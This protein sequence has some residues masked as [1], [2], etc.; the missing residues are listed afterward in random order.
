MGTM[1]D[2]HWGIWTLG[3]FLAEAHARRARVPAVRWLVLA[4]V[5]AALGCLLSAVLLQPPYFGIVRVDCWAVV[6]GLLLAALLVSGRQRTVQLV[7]AAAARL[8]FLGQISYS[9]YL[10]HYPWMAFLSAC[11]RAVPTWR[12]SAADVARG[13]MGTDWRLLSRTVR[14]VAP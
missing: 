1:A 8:R 13:Q 6:L 5:A 3:A 7:E 11:W 4:S 9:M 12:N 14:L 2:A 10:V